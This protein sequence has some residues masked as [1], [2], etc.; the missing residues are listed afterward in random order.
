[1]TRDDGHPVSG[2]AEWRD[3]V[4]RLE[5]PPAPRDL[6]GR[7]VAERAKGTRVVLPGGEVAVSPP[8]V[9]LRVVAAAA[10]LLVIGLAVLQRWPAG[11]AARRDSSSSGEC[12]MAPDLTR[13]LS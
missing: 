13:L 6:I 12:A 2:D 11:G 9:R 3:A 5:A 10:V 7:V 1:M 4:G 8:V